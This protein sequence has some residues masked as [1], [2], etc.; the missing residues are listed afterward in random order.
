MNQRLPVPLFEPFYLE[1]IDALLP[2]MPF[3]LFS[4]GGDVS[5]CLEDFCILQLSNYGNESKEKA[6]TFYS[7]GNNAK[8]KKLFMLKFES[9]KSFIENLNL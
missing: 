6:V 7:A 8:R 2:E 5:D 9:I 4:G 1:P 3:L